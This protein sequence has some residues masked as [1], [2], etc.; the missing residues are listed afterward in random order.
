LARLAIV[1]RSTNGTPTT[2][3]PMTSVQNPSRTPITLNVVRAAK[4]KASAGRSS[5]D[6]N[7]ESSARAH[8][9]GFRAM[10]RAP[11]TPSTTETTVA[12]SATA[13]TVPGRLL[14]LVGLCPGAMPPEREPVGRKP[15]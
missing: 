5:G 14:Q 4:P 6:M 10:A 11:A 12:A 8:A 9:A 7:S 13:K 1:V 2:T 3:W 15:E